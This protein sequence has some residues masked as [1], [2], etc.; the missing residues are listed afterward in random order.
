M[1]KLVQDLSQ[2]LRNVPF[3]AD[4]PDA[5]AEKDTMDKSGVD[6]YGLTKK[7]PPCWQISKGGAPE[8]LHRQD[9]SDG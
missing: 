7:I 4:N 9:G 6:G 1:L 2:G 3:V 5:F 8:I